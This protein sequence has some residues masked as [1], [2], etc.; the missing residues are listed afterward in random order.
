MAGM[1]TLQIIKTIPKFDGENFIKWTRSLNDIL[2]IVWPF[3]SKII[4][5]LER[6]KPILSGSREGEEDTSDLDDND[7]N[8][9]DVSGHSSGSL[10]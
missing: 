8:P 10:N 2:Q 1:N 6:P 9:S 7:S 4:Y 3:L 5:G